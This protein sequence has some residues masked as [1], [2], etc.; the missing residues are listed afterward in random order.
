LAYAGGKGK[1][2]AG[3][4]GRLQDRCHTRRINIAAHKTLKLKTEIASG[5]SGMRADG[6]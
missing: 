5:A 2:S 4:V 1:K 6:K 3:S